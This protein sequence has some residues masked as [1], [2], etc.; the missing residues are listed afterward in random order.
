[1]YICIRIRESASFCASDFFIFSFLFLVFS[2]TYGYFYCYS[3][4]E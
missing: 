2:L 3:V 1:M 4:I